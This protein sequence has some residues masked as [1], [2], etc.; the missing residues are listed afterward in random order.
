MTRVLV[1]QNS[2]QA[3]KRV[4]GRPFQP[5]QSGNPGGRP[6]GLVAAIRAQTRDGEE[7]VR[8][9]LAVLRGRV[10]GSRLRDRMAAAEWLADRGFGRPV[11]AVGVAMDAMDDRTPLE[12][13]RAIT[14]GHTGPPGGV[15]DY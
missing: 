1:A 9:M 11:Q 15:Y 6:R 8:F 14:A 2:D 5:G 7:L 12:V 10:P 3:A 13:I 4:R